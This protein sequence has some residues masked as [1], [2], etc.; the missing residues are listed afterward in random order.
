MVPTLS[1]RATLF[2]LLIV[3]AVAALVLHETGKLAFVEG[4][5]LDWL[6]P[7]LGTTTGAR[8]TAESAGGPWD[9]ASLRDKV[10]ELQQQVD[11]MTLDNVRLRELENENNQLREQL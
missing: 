8:S 3:I 9:I 10:A 5:A 2:V 1:N 7:V 4:I 11:A 6:A